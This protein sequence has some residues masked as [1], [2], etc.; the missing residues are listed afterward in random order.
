MTL[1]AVEPNEPTLAEWVTPSLTI[2]RGRDPL[3]LQTITL[4]R[5]MPALLPGVLALSERARY[6]TIYPFLLSEYQR[7]RLAADNA[8]L[9]EFIR[10]R[11][12]ELCLAMQL[13]PRQCGAA[14]AIGSDRAR[15]DARAEPHEFPRR[16]SVESRWGDTVC[17]TARRWSTSMS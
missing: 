13:C 15:P 1:T 6:L 12:Y 11:E 14:K 4:D 16:L 5:I 17:T 10:L 8:S 9:G 2:K 3:G 7:R